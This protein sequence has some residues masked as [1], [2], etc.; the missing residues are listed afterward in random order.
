[1]LAHGPALDD[2]KARLQELLEKLRGMSAEDLQSSNAQV[3]LLSQ[4]ADKAIVG[5]P[6]W[7]KDLRSGATAE[8]E[9]M[10]AEAVRLVNAAWIQLGPFAVEDIQSC[11][12]EWGIYNDLLSH[13]GQEA[14]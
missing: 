3:Q 12:K 5:M 9:T 8:I 1:M 4:L 11:I 6:T 2:L 7:S 14:L 10:F 13:M